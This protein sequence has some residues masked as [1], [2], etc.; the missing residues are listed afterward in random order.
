MTQQV[1]EKSHLYQVLAIRTAMDA[2]AQVR[3]KPGNQITHLVLKMLKSL[4]HFFLNQEELKFVKL[5][6]HKK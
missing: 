3:K 4:Y 5:K 6:P 2:M 1:K